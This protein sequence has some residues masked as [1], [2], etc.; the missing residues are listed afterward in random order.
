MTFLLLYR[1]AC[2]VCEFNSTNLQ[3]FRLRGL[4]KESRH[5]RNYLLVNDDDKMDRP[6]FK[7]F[8]SSIIYWVGYF[9]WEP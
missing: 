3:I 6:Y 7:G 8:S 9:K 1:L 5:D 4:C 2:T